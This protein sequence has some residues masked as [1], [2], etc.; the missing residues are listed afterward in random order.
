M[1]RSFENSSQYERS[2]VDPEDQAW[3]DWSNDEDEVTDTQ[4]LFCQDIL[5]DPLKAFQHMKEAHQFDFQSL[6]HS[7]QL[8]FYQC[9][10]LINYVRSQKLAAENVL[11]LNGEEKFWEDEVYLKPVL[12][13]DPLLFAF[14][15]LEFVENENQQQQEPTITSS[16]TTSNS[17][18]PDLINLKATTE[19]EK[20]LLSLLEASQESKIN[21]EGQ[22]EEYKQMVKK[23]FYE[24]L[25]N[26]S[27]NKNDQ[28][29]KGFIDEGNYYFNGYAHNDIH[30]Q[31]LKDTARTE[32]YRDFIYENKDIFKNKIVL[33]VGCGTGILSM[34]AAKAGAKQVFSVDNSAIIEKAKRN[35]KENEL[36]HII[37]CIRGKVEE[38][39][40][41]VPQV[42]IIVSE[43]MGYFLLFEAMLDSVLV[44]RDRW[45]APK[46][47]MAPSQT[48]ILMAAL[49]DE[50]LKDDRVNFWNDVYGFKMSAMKEPTLNEAVIDF[51]KPESV[52]SDII[53]LKDLPLQTV[54][55]KQLDFVC[56]YE[57]K[58]NKDGT[59]YAFGG[60]FDT[61]F[62]RD[63]HDIPADRGAEKVKGEIYLT[64]SPLGKDTHWKQTAFILE[65]PIQVK[66]GD[67][68]RG[69][70]TCHK[71]VDNPRELECEVEY[72]VN[73]GGSKI[74]NF[75]IKS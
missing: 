59:L 35:I 53:T 5:A 11:K 22:F 75:Y 61:W 60:W 56:K 73:N 57:M 65:E 3:D 66:A 28:V 8:D 17:A 74:Q 54:T 38:I 12:E 32:A 34:F 40:L 39:E 51:L 69:V 55:A 45:L 21:L 13:D 46:G 42:D 18:L 26:D 4:C 16:N 33:D 41:P 2:E 25:A 43:W 19:L 1:S 20:H 44:A 27:S 58:I 52:I 29:N 48:R 47:I 64:T 36:D 6:K 7:L 50:D 10:R 14:E 37:T 72:S 62:T 24:P 67:K 68:I 49:D 23:T 15:E 31:M 70:F 63:G 30:E 9:I 71:G